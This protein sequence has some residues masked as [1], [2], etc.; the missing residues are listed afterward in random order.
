MEYLKKEELRNLLVFNEQPVELYF[1]KKDGTKRRMLATLNEDL[2]PKNL[3][4]KT[5]SPK[6]PDYLHVFDTEIQEWR[7]VIFDSIEGLVY[8]R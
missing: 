1:V 2:I 3:R 6:M 5:A 4:P 7:T 8:T